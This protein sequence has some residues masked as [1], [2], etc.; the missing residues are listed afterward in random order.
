MGSLLNR[1]YVLAAP[2]EEEATLLADL[3][4]VFG[5]KLS[6]STSKLRRESQKQFEFRCYYFNLTKRDGLYLELQPNADGKGRLQAPHQNSAGWVLRFRVS[7]DYATAHRK[8]PKQVAQWA[9]S[10]VKKLK[11]KATFLGYED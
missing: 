3:V 8:D 7:E 2:V 5:R 6:K 10:C 9:A 4:R 1:T 11:F